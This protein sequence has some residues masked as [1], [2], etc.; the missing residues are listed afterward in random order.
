[1]LWE[2]ERNIMSLLPGLS[3]RGESEYGG[4]HG[5]DLSLARLPSSSDLVVST[6]WRDLANSSP[7]FISLSLS[8]PVYFLA[9]QVC[10]NCLLPDA[11][12]EIVAR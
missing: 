5:L 8:F 1:M 4:S 7:F 3:P 9:G 6:D 2:R 10:C 11:W 12:T